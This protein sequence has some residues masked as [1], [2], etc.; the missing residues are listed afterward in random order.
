MIHEVPVVGF[1]AAGHSITRNPV[2]VELDGDTVRLTTAP[3]DGE[4]VAGTELLVYETEVSD[5]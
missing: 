2:L 5:G 3:D 1:S 4:E